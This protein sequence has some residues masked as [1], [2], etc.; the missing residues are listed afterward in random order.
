[1]ISLLNWA[2]IASAEEKTITKSETI[3]ISVDSDSGDITKKIIVNGKELSADEIAEFEA[4][5]KMKTIHMGHGD[6]EG[7]KVMVIKGDGSHHTSMNK[8]V[9]VIKKHTD[10]GDDE[11]IQVFIEKD[12]DTTVEKILVNGKELTDEEIEEFK[13]SG[14][15]K[16]IHLDSDMDFD[17]ELHEIEGHKV[18]VFKSDSEFGEDVNVEVIMDKLSDIEG[19]HLD[20]ST[21][22]EWI[23]EDGKNIKIIKKGVFAVDDGS[24][25]LGFVAAVENDGWHLS[26]IMEKS[27][28]K[29]AGILE[30]DIVTNIGGTDLTS[31]SDSGKFNVHALP[32]FEEG[33]MVKVTLMRDGQPI[34]FDVQAR[35]LDKSAL[36]VDLLSKGG[37]HNEWIEK[38]HEDGGVSKNIK[39]MVIDTIEENQE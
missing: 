7:H 15:M 2:F 12:G 24:A 29:D 33:E 5:G 27:G 18:M 13:A 21:V 36:T 34:T 28:A 17:S 26:K 10:N 30:G 9:R 25:S 32:K 11:D 31:N 35:M 22:Q 37:E 19:L 3:E 16:V 39:V 20:D 1:M 23:S 38:L 14:K 6:G 4:S 8:Q